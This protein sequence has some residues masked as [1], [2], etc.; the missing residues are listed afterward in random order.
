MFFIKGFQKIQINYALCPETAKPVFHFYTELDSFVEVESLSLFLQFTFTSLTLIPARQI[1]DP[2]P[3]ILDVLNHT[4]A[5][6]SYSTVAVVSVSQIRRSQKELRRGGEK[7]AKGKEETPH[8][9]SKPGALYD[10]PAVPTAMEAR[11]VTPALSW[12]SPGR[13]PAALPAY[14]PLLKCY[15]RQG[16]WCNR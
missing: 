16:K 8:Y 14:C 11:L 13:H 3:F 2:V 12:N 7:R 4:D 5:S 1:R 15:L 6:S 10:S 9:L